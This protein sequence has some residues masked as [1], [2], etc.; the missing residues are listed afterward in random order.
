MGSTFEKLFSSSFDFLG[1]YTARVNRVVLTFGV[2]LPIYS[3]S[4]D[5]D[6]PTQ[7]VRFEP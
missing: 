1:F 6:A 4:T 2:P 5:I 7:L 3:L